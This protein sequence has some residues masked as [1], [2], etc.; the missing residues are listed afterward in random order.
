MK[1]GENEL[2]DLVVAQ[3]KKSNSGISIKD[4]T[5]WFYIGKYSLIFY[6][7]KRFVNQSLLILSTSFFRRMERR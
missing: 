1:K 4:S 6:D 2:M 5:S 3:T 7:Y